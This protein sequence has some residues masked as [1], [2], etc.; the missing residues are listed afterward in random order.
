MRWLGALSLWFQ[1]ISKKSVAH[2]FQLVALLLSIPC[3]KASHFFF[4]IV[5]SLQQRRLRELGGEGFVLAI[6]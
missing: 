2:C 4:K 1:G 3:F 6:L 5:Y